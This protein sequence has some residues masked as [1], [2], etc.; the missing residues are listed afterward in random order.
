MVA[1][2]GGGGAGRDEFAGVGDV[3]AEVFRAV[4]DV[5]DDFVEVQIGRQTS[6]ALVLPLQILGLPGL[7][8][9][10]CPPCSFR[11]R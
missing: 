10:Q 8:G 1:Y 6:E 4:P 7:V 9:F 2:D 3:D 11:Q 5:E